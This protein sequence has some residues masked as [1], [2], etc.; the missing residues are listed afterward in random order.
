MLTALLASAMAD[1]AFKAWIESVGLP[2]LKSTW[3]PWIISIVKKA[4]LEIIADFFHNSKNA[5][6]SKQSETILT[7]LA[8]ATTDEERL[9]AHKA[10]QALMATRS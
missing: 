10:F 3:E 5:E 4:A 7:S 1:P 8:T 6:F 2:W 9:N